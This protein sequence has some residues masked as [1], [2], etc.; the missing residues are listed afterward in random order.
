MSITNLI[1]FGIA[2]GAYIVIRF[3]TKGITMRQKFVF[4]GSP[5]E[6][7][8]NTV[9]VP[10]PKN[11]PVYINGEQEVNISGLTQLSIKGKSLEP[12]DIKDGSTV[13]VKELNKS[14][15]SELDLNTLIGRFVVFTIDNDR[16]LQE[17]PLKNISIVEGALKIRKVI[18]I[19][20]SGIEKDDIKEN[21][22][23][24][25]TD[26]DADF[27]KLTDEEKSSTLDRVITKYEFASKYYNNPPKLIM[28]ITYK[29]NGTRKDYSFHSPKFLYGI[30]QY[31]SL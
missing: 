8:S 19:I 15:I 9:V 16:T 12:L 24:F 27:I 4:A 6:E 1:V 25:L 31:N 2:C 7:P 28:S 22:A 14:E 26:N 17:H 13:F 10:I 30:V 5:S 3:I 11:K 21:I 18:K 20:N 23:K 29:D